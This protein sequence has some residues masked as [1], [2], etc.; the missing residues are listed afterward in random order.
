MAYIRGFWGFV[1]GNNVGFSSDGL[2]TLIRI[3]VIAASPVV[4]S[5]SSILKVFRND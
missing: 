3:F 1:R 4:L 2:S 5:L